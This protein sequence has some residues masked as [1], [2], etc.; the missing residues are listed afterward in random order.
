VASH[1]RRYGRIIVWACATGVRPEEWAAL[2]WIDLDLRA[3][4]R[5]VSQVI[6][7]G[8]IKRAGKTDGAL[9][10]VALPEAALDVVAAMVRPL[11]SRT[12]VFTASRG[13]RVSLRN[14]RS[15]LWY[16]ALSQVSSGGLPISVAIRSRRWPSRPGPMCTG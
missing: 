13:G 14:F 5:R 6:V 15:R 11:A 4:T 7:E 3:K 10:T 2:R 1:A 9:R 12:L 8:V 16:D